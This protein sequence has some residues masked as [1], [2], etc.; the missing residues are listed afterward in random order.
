YIEHIIDELER[1]Y[2]IDDA[3][4]VKRYYLEAVRNDREEGSKEFIKY[5]NTRLERVKDKLERLMWTTTQRDESSVVLST[6]HGV[7]GEEYKYVFYMPT[8]RAPARRTQ[9]SEDMPKDERE[10]IWGRYTETH[11]IHYVAPTRAIEQL[12]I[13]SEANEL[14]DKRNKLNKLIAQNKPYNADMDALLQKLNQPIYR[15][16]QY[17][18]N[19]EA[20]PPKDDEEDGE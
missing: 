6:V 9:V 2:I 8:R 10:N 17:D 18:E 12:I 1:F 15:A 13:I 20:I 19:G 11:N 14:L 5:L 3:N 4:P 16:V 7:K